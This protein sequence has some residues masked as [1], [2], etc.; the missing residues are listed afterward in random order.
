MET[1]IRSKN[2]LGL[3]PKN[4]GIILITETIADRFSKLAALETRNARTKI[5]QPINPKIN[6]NSRRV[7][8]KAPFI[9]R[10]YYIQRSKLVI[11]IWDSRRVLKRKIIY[12]Q[13]PSNPMTNTAYNLIIFIL[14]FFFH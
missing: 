13:K 6:N 3:P 1:P 10:G 8:L 4:S 2:G 7:I 12:G 11:K 5:L 9:A 14:E